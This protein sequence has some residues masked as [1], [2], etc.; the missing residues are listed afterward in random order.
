MRNIIELAASEPVEDYYQE[1]AHYYLG[2]IYYSKN[3]TERAIQSFE[4]C[5]EINPDNHS[6]VYVLALI[7]MDRYALDDA[8]RFF[9]ALSGEIP[10]Q[11]EDKAR[12]G[13]S[14]SQSRSSRRRISAA[15]VKNTRKIDGL[16]A[17]ALYDER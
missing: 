10:R 11:R 15:R 3:Q 1:Y 13:A 4:H 9:P 16:L 12:H 8:A 14:I 2:H 17:S 5:L 7:H 6:A